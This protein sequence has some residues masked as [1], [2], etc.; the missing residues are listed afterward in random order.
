[1][2]GLPSDRVAIHPYTPEWARL[3]QEEKAL[4][5]SGIGDYVLDVQHIGST[6][7]PGLAAKPIIDI[8]GSW[9]CAGLACLKSESSLIERS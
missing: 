2:I 1:M 5:L 7:V 4:I 3:F 9:I 8:D 6:S